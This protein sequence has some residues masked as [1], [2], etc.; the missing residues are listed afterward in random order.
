MF[1]PKCNNVLTKPNK[2]AI[3]ASGEMYLSE[4]L[5]NRLEECYIVKVS[6]PCE[7]K[8]SFQVGGKWFCPGCGVQETE[9]DGFVRCPVCDLSLNE[10]IYELI[11]RSP[12]NNL[13]DF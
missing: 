10:F 12:H 8:F 2:E 13:N 11:E 3:C 7:L 4:H 5:T 6:I 9:F 1:C